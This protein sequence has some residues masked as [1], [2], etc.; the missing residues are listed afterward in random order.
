MRPSTRLPGPPD[1][2][3]ISG[4]TH[5]STGGEEETEA[6]GDDEDEG[7]FLDL[8]R[9]AL[10]GLPSESGEAGEGAASGCC[11]AANPLLEAFAAREARRAEAAAAVAAAAISAA[12][13][14]MLRHS[15][16]QGEEVE[17]VATGVC[18]NDMHSLAYKYPHHTPCHTT[19]HTKPT[20]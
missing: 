8:N 9:V 4:G 14:V 7:P 20:P 1:P 18:T 6:G 11:T 13:T 15:C 16:V 12:R 10:T 17:R 19:L 2:G 5:A 3:T